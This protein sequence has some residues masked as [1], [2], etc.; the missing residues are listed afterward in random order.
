LLIF[1]ETSPNFQKQ[2]I[3]EKPELGLDYE[4]SQSELVITS[5]P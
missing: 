4:A 5:A 2:K 3:A 1:F